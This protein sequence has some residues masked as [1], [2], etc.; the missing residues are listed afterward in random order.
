MYTTVINPSVLGHPLA[1][2][3]LLWL[4]FAKPLLAVVKFLFSINRAA[5]IPSFLFNR[6]RAIWRIGCQRGS[7]GNGHQQNGKKW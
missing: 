7:L 2:S 1:F 4:V 6:L 3:H 5:N